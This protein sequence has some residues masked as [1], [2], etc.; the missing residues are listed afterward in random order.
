MC[1]WVFFGKL[2]L[3]SQNNKVADHVL[4]KRG[5]SMEFGSYQ[6]GKFYQD[7]RGLNGAKIYEQD[8]RLYL[9]ISY[10]NVLDN[11][12]AAFRSAP[13]EIAFKTYG[14]VSLFTF[15]FEN[16]YIVDTP[17]N[18]FAKEKI[19]NKE[20]YRQGMELPLTIFVFES[21]NG[22][23]M[24][25]RKCRLPQEFSRQ[26]AELMEERHV[27]YAGKYNFEAFNRGI[28]EIYDNHVIDEL[29]KLPG[30]REVVGYVGAV[31]M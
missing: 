29:Y 5:K 27:E 21:S 2:E 30:D 23:L 13:F 12:V 7:F 26:L 22:L 18:Q 16:E 8:G 14:L 15:R 1:W 19:L 3:M 24:E 31:V 25:K 4:T 20:A 6:V 11:E 10:D 28:K 9:V 17:F